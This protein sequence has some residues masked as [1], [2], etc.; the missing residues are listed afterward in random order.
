MSV[1]EWGPET[2][3]GMDFGTYMSFIAAM[4]LDALG[5]VPD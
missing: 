3:S 2:Q 5:T 4:P 1:K